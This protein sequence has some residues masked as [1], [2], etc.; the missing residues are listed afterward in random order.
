MPKDVTKACRTATTNH[1][2]ANVYLSADRWVCGL[3]MKNIVLSFVNP[4]ES[5]ISSWELVEP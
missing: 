2:K 4:G 3:R 5:S 1:N